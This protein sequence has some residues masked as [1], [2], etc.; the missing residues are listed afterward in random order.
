MKEE[1][2]RTEQVS[3]QAVA[4]VLG[5]TLRWR[6]TPDAPP[7]THDCDIVLAGGRIVAAEVTAVTLPAD[8]ALE[9]ELEKNFRAPLPGLRGIWRVNVTGRLPQGQ[10]PRAYARE[11]RV[12]LERLLGRFEAGHPSL[13][14]LVELD[15]RWP[16]PRTRIPQHQR[17]H[18]EHVNTPAEFN[19]WS[20]RA[21]ERFGCSEEAVEALVEMYEARVRS[22]FRLDD[23]PRQG[24]PNVFVR[25][26]IRSGHVGPDDLAEAVEREAA[27]RDNRLK[28]ASACAHEH[29]LVVSFDL[30]SL[31]GWN[32]RRDE[33]SLADR[34]YPRPPL[35]PEEV[36][37]AWAVLP[38]DPPIVW[39][40]NRGDPAWTRP[41]PVT[42]T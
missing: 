30:M 33:A 14:E 41:R 29:H 36:D 42:W 7:G 4:E 35:L 15:R 5:G 6:D 19:P 26:P 37:T 39:R 22:A 20:Q 8:R 13:D 28:L 21:S 31:K 24:E 10:L 1:D 38:S 9:A 2:Q 3:A 32:V 23:R 18:D 11:L 25:C 17:L 16:N 34:G 12:R 40:Y 27:K